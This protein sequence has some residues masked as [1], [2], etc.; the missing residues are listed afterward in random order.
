MQVSKSTVIFSDGKTLYPSEEYIADEDPKLVQFK[1]SSRLLG[2]R[3]LN[4]RIDALSLCLLRLDLF[5]PQNVL[6]VI[7]DCLWAHHCE[8]VLKP[9]ETRAWQQAQLQCYKD[10]SCPYGDS[11][12]FFFGD[13]LDCTSLYPSSVPSENRTRA[14][15]PHRW[16]EEFYNKSTK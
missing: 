10:K 14:G 3:R 8:T 16:I 2:L 9:L 7:R 15:V 11:D 4:E 6:R 1:V 5:F 13:R 12:S